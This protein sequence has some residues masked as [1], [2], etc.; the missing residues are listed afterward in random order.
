MK[1]TEHDEQVALIQWAKA[2]EGKY[3]ALKM[4]FAIPSGQLR[5]YSTR[6]DEHG[7]KVRYSPIGQKLRAEGVKSGVPDLFLGTGAIFV[8]SLDDGFQKVIFYNGL[9]IEMKSEKGRT[10]KNQDAWIEALREQGYKV[11]VCH[12]FDEARQVICDYLGIEEG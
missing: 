3:P 1:T 6:I 10:T 4:L 8:K 9:F 11:E 7:Q 2:N 5:P 12:G